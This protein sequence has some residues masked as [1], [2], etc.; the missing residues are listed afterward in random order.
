MA[1]TDHIVRPD[2]PAATSST[3]LSNRLLI[4]LFLL[5]FVAGAIAAGWLLSRS[6]WWGTD[7]ETPAALSAVE[8]TPPPATPAL[9]RLADSVD[10]TTGGTRSAVPVAG[11]P[12]AGSLGP[13]S[14]QVDTL[15]ARLATIRAAV[16]QAETNG[17]RAEAMLLAVAARRTLDRG[18]PLGFLQT[19]LRARFPGQPR[20]VDT[21]VTS[22]A[23]PVTVESLRAG[24]PDLDQVRTGGRLLALVR[25]DGPPLVAIRRAGQPSRDPTRRLAEAGEA[26]GRGDVASAVAQVAAMRATPDRST[27]LRT[28]RRYLDARQAL[29]VIETAAILQGSGEAPPSG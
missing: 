22:A 10:P 2:Q 23:D 4:G 18:V 26:L 17:R 21:I 24:L 16:D 6:G 19:Q 12:V 15:E 7:S 27:W 1:T 8:Q 5:T 25:G 28:A 9:A 13:V 14:E 20:A 29:D 3:T 11:T